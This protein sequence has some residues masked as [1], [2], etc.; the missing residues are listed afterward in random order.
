MSE[1]V[2]IKTLRTGVPRA[3][4]FEG[5]DGLDSE[6]P[7]WCDRR[8]WRAGRLRRQLPIPASPPCCLGRCLRTRSGASIV[9]GASCSPE[10][11]GILPQVRA[12]VH[13]THGVLVAVAALILVACNDDDLSSTSAGSG[14]AGGAGGM[15]GDSPAPEPV[16][17][18]ELGGQV[19][20]P[21]H[22]EELEG[23][24][25]YLGT[26][27]MP[28]AS[29]ASV[30]EPLEPITRIGGNLS[31]FRNH[32]L[33]DLRGLERLVHVGESIVLR[34]DDSHGAFTSL[35][36]LTN[37]REAGGLTLD[38]IPGLTSLDGLA[39]LET[40]HGDVYI[41]RNP[42]LSSAEIDAFLSRVEV[43]GEIVVEENGL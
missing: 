23:C 22:P 3:V 18:G 41:A 37:V 6:V 16:V 39:S 32:G 19:D 2:S 29:D 21:Y 38:S 5:D 36:G 13:A 12:S 40:I 24:T 26:V 34:L 15:G 43:E 27:H 20:L 1:A 8:R 10:H 14:G 25:E 7:G 33:T 35:A 42:E 30:L 17:C 4:I 11:S 28:D 31:V 9:I